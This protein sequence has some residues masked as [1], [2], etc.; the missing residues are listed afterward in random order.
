[1]SG[2]S[3]KKSWSEFHNFAFPVSIVMSQTVHLL[4]SF[5]SLEMPANRHSAL[6]LTL[7]SAIPVEQ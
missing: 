3:G 5:M 7:D 4:L 6:W 1:M 2:L